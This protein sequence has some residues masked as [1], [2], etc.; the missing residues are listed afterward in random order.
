M[1]R[2]TNGTATVLLLSLIGLAFIAGE[3]Q[4][5]LVGAPSR[6]PSRPQSN[7]E[8][9][10]E[11][12]LAEPMGEQSDDFFTT[13]QGFSSSTGY[14][15]GLRFRQYLSDWFAVSPSFHYTRF[16]EATGVNDFGSG[17]EVPYSIRISNYRYSFDLH[18][19]MGPG[20][21]SFRPYLIGGI[22]LINNKY[23]DEIQNGGIYST[24]INTPA[25]HAG[26]GFKMRNVE[27]VGEYFY[28]RFD[29]ANLP[30][31]DGTRTYNWDY[32]VVRVAFSFGR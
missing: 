31:G 24:S 27:L 30:P 7:S 14:E 10:L 9:I 6:R 17:V 25:Y 11:G 2:L 28:N 8:F 18:A 21:A 1:K 4:A 20:D 16:G 13:E 19:F 15:L 23:R 22:E 5:K 3:V 32:L 12:A 26:L 29:T